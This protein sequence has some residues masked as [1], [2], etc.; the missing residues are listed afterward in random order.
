MVRLE[1]LIQNS[2]IESIGA[3]YLHGHGTT[4]LKG[5]RDILPSLLAATHKQVFIDSFKMSE[6]DLNMIFMNARNCKYLNI[7]NCE[8]GTFKNRINIPKDAVY[9]LRDLDLFWTAIPDN[10][11]YLDEHKLVALLKAFNGTLLGKKLRKIHVS[12]D[13][14]A[15]R[16][17]MA[18]IMENNGFKTTLLTYD[19]IEPEVY[20]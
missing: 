4:K 15:H 13:D 18:S 17:D 16:E 8:V 9:K 2:R 11:N 1:K 7:V 19:T 14:F 5:F 20:Y 10:S 6:T 12:K 3:L